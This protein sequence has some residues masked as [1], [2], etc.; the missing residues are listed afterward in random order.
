MND[1]ELDQCAFNGCE[2]G[3]PLEV[4]AD[5]ALPCSGDTPALCSPP[6]P[7]VAGLVVFA[8][9]GRVEKSYSFRTVG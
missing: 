8:R 2:P 6:S 1:S 3:S 9:F 5:S 7:Y 4:A